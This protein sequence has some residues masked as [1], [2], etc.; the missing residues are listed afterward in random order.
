MTLIVVVSLSL[1]VM[2]EVIVGKDGSVVF[3]RKC[4]ITMCTFV[5]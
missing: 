4:I 2:Q 5:K 1:K 3:D